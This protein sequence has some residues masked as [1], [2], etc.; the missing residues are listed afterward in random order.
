[1]ATDL[2]VTEFKFGPAICF[3]SFYISTRPKRGEC[4]LVRSVQV[5]P[6]TVQ[7]TLSSIHVESLLLQDSVTTSDRRQPNQQLTMK[8]VLHEDLGTRLLI[9]LSQLPST[10]SAMASNRFV[11]LTMSL[12]ALQEAVIRRFSTLSRSSGL[13]PSVRERNLVQHTSYHCWIYVVVRNTCFD[14]V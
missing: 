8:D 14:T 12:T 9:M 1:M 10:C 11:F 4:F 13:V 2:Q 6:L 7:F 5:Q 3:Y